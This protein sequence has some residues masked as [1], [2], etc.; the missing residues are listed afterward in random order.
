MTQ[1]YLIGEF[2]QL[3]AGLQPAPNELLEIATRDLRCDVEFG[4]LRAL[5]D[6]AREAVALADLIC[7][8][9]LEAGDASLFSHYVASASALEE[10]LVSA[11]L[12]R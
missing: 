8:A 10:F 12:L 9:A 1:H 6:L 5:P 3:L 4:P 7:A 11:N 2:S